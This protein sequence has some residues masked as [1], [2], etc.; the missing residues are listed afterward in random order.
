MFVTT[1]T[2]PLDLPWHGNYRGLTGMSTLTRIYS[3]IIKVLSQELPIHG[4]L[5]I[6]LSFAKHCILFE[7]ISLTKM[8]NDILLVVMQI[9][10]I[11]LLLAVH[12]GNTLLVEIIISVKPYKVRWLFYLLSK[13]LIKNEVQPLSGW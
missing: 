7:S 9:D 6:S 2:T 10:I 3:L 12:R 11:M 4:I 1:P 5:V 13:P 8:I